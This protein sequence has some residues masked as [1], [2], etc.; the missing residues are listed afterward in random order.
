[1]ETGII[2]TIILAFFG[3]V[4]SLWYK[5]GK[6]ESSI[7][8]LEPDKISTK[9]IETIKPALDDLGKKIRGLSKCLTTYKKRVDNLEHRVGALEDKTRCIE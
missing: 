3:T 8:K 1:M 6:L 7:S 4:A 5:I 2:I 9:V